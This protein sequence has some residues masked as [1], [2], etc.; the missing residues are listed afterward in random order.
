LTFKI[1]RELQGLID[2][3]GE[4]NR[5]AVELLRQ[6]DLPEGVY[7]LCRKVISLRS[8]AVKVLKMYEFLASEGL[9]PFVKFRIEGL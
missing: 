9:L 8:R 4:S 5:I 2:G 7:L 6:E 1:V 3:L